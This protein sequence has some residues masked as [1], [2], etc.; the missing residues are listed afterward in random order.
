VVSILCITAARISVCG[1]AMGVAEHGSTP[2]IADGAASR[3]QWV[4]AGIAQLPLLYRYL[5]CRAG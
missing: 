4:E 2:G 5:I 3:N 1:S